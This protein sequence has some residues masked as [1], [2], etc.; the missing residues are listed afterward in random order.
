MR[1]RKGDIFL[2]KYTLKLYIFDGKGWLE[3]ISS[4]ELKKN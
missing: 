2:D 4:C 1:Y 3:I